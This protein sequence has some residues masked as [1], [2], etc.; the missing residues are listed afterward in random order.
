M[1]ELLKI[2]I[3]Y[4]VLMQMSDV[5][6]NTILGVNYGIMQKVSEDSRK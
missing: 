5:D 3:P 1:L 6:I 4:D 2:G